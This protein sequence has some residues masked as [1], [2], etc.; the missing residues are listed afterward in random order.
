MSAQLANRKHWIRPKHLHPSTGLA[1]IVSF[2]G[3]VPNKI[4]A[5]ALV[6][7]RTDRIASPR[8]AQRLKT[9]SFEEGLERFFQVVTFKRK[10]YSRLKKT[11]LAAAVKALACKAKSVHRGI[12]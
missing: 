8:C 5:A 12:V 9:K 4:L 2:D 7:Y 6:S 10:A 1:L 3:L 11:N